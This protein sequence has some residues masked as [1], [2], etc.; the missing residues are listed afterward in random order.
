M[1]RFTVLLALGCALGAFAA[2]PQERLPTVEVT[3]GKETKRYAPA[4][5]VA[6]VTMFSNALTVRPEPLERPVVLLFDDGRVA[7][8]EDAV[9]GGAPYRTAEPG[10][11]AVEALQRAVAALDASTERTLTE[12]R[13]GPDATYATLYVRAVGGRRVVMKSWHPRDPQSRVVATS[14]GLVAREGRDPAAVLAA[15]TPDYQRFRKTWDAL[16]SL[17]VGFTRD[18]KDAQ[19]AKVTASWAWAELP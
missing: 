15:D 10:P 16:E 5:V 6:F 9:K 18:A 12:T 7:W 11:A 14:R 3:V 2:A 4:Q 13:L 8:S 17:L 1:R 19:A